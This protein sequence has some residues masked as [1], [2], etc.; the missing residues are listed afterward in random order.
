MVEKERRGSCMEN[1]GGIDARNGAR[2]IEWLV[3]TVC[4]DLRWTPGRTPAVDEARKSSLVRCNIGHCKDSLLWANR[5]SPRLRSSLVKS[6]AGH[7]SVT[8]SLQAHATSSG[9]G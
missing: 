3:M 1:V 2:H 9:T 6:L 4:V 7:N 8:A 5:S